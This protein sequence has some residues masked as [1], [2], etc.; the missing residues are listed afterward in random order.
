MVRPSQNLIIFWAM[1]DLPTPALIGVI[2]LPALPG[3]PRH[4]LSMDEIVERAVADA[5][6]L[7]RAGFDA[8]IVENFGDIPFPHAALPPATVAAMAV[9]AE[10][11]RREAALPLGINALRNDAASALGIAAASGAKFIRVN[12]HTGVY[13]ADQGIIQGRADETLRYRKQLGLRI[14]ILADVN[15]K[16]AR[17][18]SEPDIARAAKDTAY[19]GLADGLIVTGAAT[20]EAADL[21]QL[22]SVREAVPD[23]RLFVGSGATADSVGEILRI[24][25]GVIVGTSIKKGRDT[26]NSIDAD[27][28][29]R[30][31]RAARGG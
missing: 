3:A 16:H 30:F 12:V 5:R 11:V 19:R 18:L 24:A 15:V 2:H 7:K 22:R 28:A 27:L 8:A 9:A 13:A 10:H 25:S 20:G 17:P 31:V 6:V 14:A 29:T 21:E 4:Q 1:L 23:R 26:A